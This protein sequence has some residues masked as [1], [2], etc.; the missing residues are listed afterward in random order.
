MTGRPQRRRHPRF[1]VDRLPGILSL[2]VGTEVVNISVSGLG[3]RSE[4]PLR[5]GRRLSFQLG[6]GEQSLDLSGTVQWCR[7]CRRQRPE[8]GQWVAVYE[9]GIAF[10]TVLT[11]QQREILRL[12][13]KTTMVTPERRFHGRYGVGDGHTMTMEAENELRV[14]RISRSGM[15]VETDAALDPESMVDVDV[16]LGEVPFHCVAR[17]VTVEEKTAGGARV[18][19]MGM[20][21]VETSPDNLAVLERFLQSQLESQHDTAGVTLDAEN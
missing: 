1:D 19:A 3:V 11:Q 13:G 15:L 9:A 14:R 12:M 18:V 10:D 20:E 8:D 21:F 7:L 17:V 16:S 2:A 6:R 4:A 5:I